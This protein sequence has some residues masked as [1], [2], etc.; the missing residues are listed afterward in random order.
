MSSED[1]N[2]HLEEMSQANNQNVNEFRLSVTS[3]EKVNRK[4]IFSLLSLTISFSFSISHL[5]V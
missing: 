1:A 4:N 3:L 5:I 2:Y